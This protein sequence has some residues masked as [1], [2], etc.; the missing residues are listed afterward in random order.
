MLFDQET[1]VAKLNTP[2]II[3]RE[4]ATH[5]PMTGL[6]H[7]YC[8]AT[9][10]TDLTNEDFQL[11]SDNVLRY[12]ISW[13]RYWYNLYK[14]SNLIGKTEEQ[15]WDES[16][17]WENKSSSYQASLV[18]TP[19]IGLASYFS[20][21]LESTRKVTV[22]VGIL[23][24]LKQA[25]KLYYYLRW[26][27][28]DGS[29][30][31]EYSHAEVCRFFKVKP[32]TVQHWHT[33]LTKCGAIRA[34]YKCLDY[35]KGHYIVGL[36]SLHKVWFNLS[37][38]SEKTWGASAEVP[39]NE[40]PGNVNRLAVQIETLHLQ[41]AS[42]RHAKA[43]LAPQRDKDGV[44]VKKYQVR[45]VLPAND[46]IQGKRIL[47]LKHPNSLMEN[48]PPEEKLLG[49]KKFF[50]RVTDKRVWISD[51]LVAY[52]TCQARIKNEL[53][54]RDSR[55]IRRHLH[56]IKHKQVFQ[57]VN[58]SGNLF[59]EAREYGMNSVDGMDLSSLYFHPS[60]KKVFKPCTNIYDFSKVGIT[61]TS[62]YAKKVQYLKLRDE[63]LASPVLQTAQ[64]RIWVAFLCMSA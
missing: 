19:L 17:N 14:S 46:L 4:L 24:E 45:K 62:N 10:R 44:K 9:G 36:G 28:P 27:N 13:F 40:L 34:G 7:Y 57:E 12:P 55:T 32:R 29:G 5:L 43:L 37:S 25:A 52:G 49:S 33:T 2:L 1:I 8:L 61:L 15:L 16:Y 30:K 23:R 35:N 63:V 20:S 58:L 6:I 51:R 26:A 41:Q 31:V 22:H 54:F 59:Y 39:L 64:G 56:K 42:Q 48:L 38:G 3:N 21:R 50:Y 53:R 60:I 18:A 47:S 11:L